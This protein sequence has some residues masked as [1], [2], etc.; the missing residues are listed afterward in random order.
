MKTK[1]A[2]K[3]FGWVHWT[4]RLLVGLGVGF[5]AVSGALVIPSLPVGIMTFAGWVVV[6]TTIVDAVN[7]VMNA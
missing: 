6:V 5:S 2:K 7:T 3:M 1:N 4:S